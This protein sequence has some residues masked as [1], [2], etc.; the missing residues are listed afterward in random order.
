FA[1][2]RLNGYRCRLTIVGLDQSGP[3]LNYA[4]ERGLSREDVVVTSCV[5]RRTLGGHYKT[6][7]AL[8]SPLW[9]DDRSITRFPNKICEYL[10]SGRPVVS[11]RIGD[12]TNFLT[13]K[14]NAYLGKPGDE[15]DF[16]GKMIA[17]LEDPN[18]AEQIGAAGQQVCIAHLDYRAHV[19][20]LAKFFAQCIEHHQERRS[21]RKDASRMGRVQTILR[22]AFCGLLAIGL[23]AS[24]RVRRSR[25]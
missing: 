7:T 20:G 2:V 23:I 8:L 4:T 11:C 17:V 14:V 3:A 1:R 22:N 21:A 16:A 6:A 5:D 24:G 10:A 18:R 15:R 19:S 13:D 12:L 9:D 25:K